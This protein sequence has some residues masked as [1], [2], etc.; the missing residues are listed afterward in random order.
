M[1][2]DG[3]QCESQDFLDILSRDKGSLVELSVERPLKHL[4]YLKKPGRL[5]LDLMFT[6]VDAKPWRASVKPWIASISNDGLVA[7]WNASMPELA[8]SEHDR[9]ISINSK[10][11]S[12]GELVDVLSAAEVIEMEVLHY[13][14]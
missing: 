7:D 12:P 14:F 2:I 4:L 9:I 10:A 6:K 8:I 13:N 5:G 3:K 1:K 11:G